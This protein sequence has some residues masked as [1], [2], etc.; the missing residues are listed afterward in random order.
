MLS[1]RHREKRPSSGRCKPA[2]LNTHF[3][4]PLLSP[5]DEL[6]L[7]DT[8]TSRNQLTLLVAIRTSN[9]EQTGPARI[10]TYSRD[11][12]GRNFTLGQI[13]NTL[14]FRL[15]TPA[16][17]GNGVDPA[18]YSGPV[19]SSNSTSLVAAVYDGRFS[20]L[21]VDGKRV[22]QADLGTRRPRLPKR[23]LMWLPHSLPVREVE[24]VGAEIL[25]SGLFAIGIF[26]LVGVPRRPLVRFFVGAAAGAAIAAIIWVFAVTQPGLGTRIL[27][28][29]VAAGLVISASVETETMNA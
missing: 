8:L 16:S 28:E 2:D 9:L 10:V 11:V 6:R 18:L 25:L 22:A 24:L 26:G 3:G 27:M 23:I 1:K 12:W 7:Y 13:R 19:L 4:R 14:T 29:C 21:Y 15:R 20:S 5:Q 17:G